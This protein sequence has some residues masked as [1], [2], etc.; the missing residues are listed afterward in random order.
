MDPFIE[1][2]EKLRLSDQTASG[3]SSKREARSLIFSDS[4]AYLN[5]ILS[6]LMCK[7]ILATSLIFVSS[8]SAASR[9]TSRVSLHLARRNLMS[10]SVRSI[11]FC[12]IDHVPTNPK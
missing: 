2:S 5:F 8:R 9:I 6:L 11:S 3:T 10:Q 7:S 12:F 4:T 1:V